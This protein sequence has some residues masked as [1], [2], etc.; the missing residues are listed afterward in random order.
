MAHPLRI[1]IKVF[2]VTSLVEDS[3]VV[4][5][6]APVSNVINSKSPKHLLTPAIVPKADACVQ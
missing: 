5:K 3:V 2:A 4:W 1:T 6:Q